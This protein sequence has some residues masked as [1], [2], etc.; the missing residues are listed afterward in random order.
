MTGSA[1]AMNEEARK[2]FFD[3]LQTEELFAADP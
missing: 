3:E 1:F 2:V